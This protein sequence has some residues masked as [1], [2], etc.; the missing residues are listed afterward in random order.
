MTHDDPRPPRQ[1][2]AET[3]AEE[4]LRG[5][6]N[7]ARSGGWATIRW[8]LPGALHTGS[9][10]PG[11]ELR[12]RGQPAGAQGKGCLWMNHLK[13]SKHKL[14]ESRAA[15]EVPK[16]F[17]GKKRLFSWMMLTGVLLQVGSPDPFIT[18]REKRMP[19]LPSP[20]H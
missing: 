9:G 19:G 18:C 14:P 11:R 12:P 6:G 15:V 3:V 2:F 7:G 16:T 5:S 10:K 13:N 4:P 20:T 8:H 1:K 17:S